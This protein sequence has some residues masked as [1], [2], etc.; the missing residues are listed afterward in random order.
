MCTYIHAYILR[1]KAWG[2]GTTVNQIGTTMGPGKGC[3]ADEATGTKGKNRNGESNEGARGGKEK[4]M[5][6][7]KRRKVVRTNHG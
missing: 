5:G 4:E 3:R 6:G 7:S 1:E 2:H